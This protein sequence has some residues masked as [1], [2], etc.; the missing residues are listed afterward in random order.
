MR[1]AFFVLNVVVIKLILLSL[2]SLIRAN[3]HL[4]I[5]YLLKCCQLIINILKV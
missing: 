5:A 4:L 1:M 3:S 2:F